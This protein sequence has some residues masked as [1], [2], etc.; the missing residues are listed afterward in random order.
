MVRVL[1]FATY[2]YSTNGY[3]QVA[4]ELAKHI[5]LNKSDIELTYYGFQ[6]FGNNPQHAKERQLPSNV[7]MYDAY[8]GEVTKQMGFGFDQVTDFVTINKP[9]VC[10]IYND[11]V[12]VSN[13][14]DKLHKVE[15]KNFK[16]I[17]YIDQVYLYQKKEF[18]KRLNEQSDYVLAFT[19]YWEDI[20]KGLGIQKPTGFLRHGFN[21]ELHYPVPTE[22]CRSYY[23]LKMSDFIVLSLNRNQPRKRYDILL[24]AWAEFVSKHMD[25]PVKLLVA[26]AIQGGW[27]LLEVYERELAKRNITLEEGLKHVIFID[28]P[29]QLTDEDVNILYNVADISLSVVDGEGFG[30]CNFQQAAIGRPQIVPRIGGFL[31]FFNDDTAIMLEPRLTFYIDSARDGVGGEAQLVDYKDAAAALERYYKDPELRKRHGENAR[32]KILKE[33]RWGPIGDKLYDIIMEVYNSGQPT[34]D[35]K[36][37]K[38]APSA[39]TPAPSTPAAS[40]PTPVPAPP[41][42]D[43]N[44]I[45]LDSLEQI[46]FGD[47]DIKFEEI[48]DKPSIQ[49][50]IQPQMDSPKDAETPPKPE[51]IPIPVVNESSD[52]DSPSPSSA[53]PKKKKKK[54]KVSQKE[55]VKDRLKKKLEDKQSTK[56][57]TGKDELDLN[58]LL[59]LKNKI[60]KL[61]AA[62]AK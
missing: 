28:N 50:L 48:P 27:N 56:I 38:E 29:Q 5:A 1:L 30:L 12:V 26:T 46:T 13:I 44:K 21:P 61:L 18:I 22:L 9:D 37:L 31:D 39:P 62:Q 43:N 42:T 45:S 34:I 55:P 58:A 15:N 47:E 16:I 36:E 11:M 6:N 2:P 57:E 35:I 4:F 53:K 23:N 19:P 10:I 33:Y 32:K 8:A 25:E 41:A 49:P 52:S 51:R 59:D 60:D 40:A 7:Q 17:V 3:S 20:V 24:Q 54:A 14:L